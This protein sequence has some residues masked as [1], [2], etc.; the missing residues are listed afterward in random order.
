MQHI[1]PTSFGNKKPLLTRMQ[2]L[3]DAIRIHTVNDHCDSVLYLTM[4]T[5]RDFAA[6]FTNDYLLDN[7]ERANAVLHCKYLY[8]DIYKEGLS[9]SHLIQNEAA[10]LKSY[11]HHFAHIA[12]GLLQAIKDF[13]SRASAVKD[14][15]PI[16]KTLADL[17]DLLLIEPPT[18][19]NSP[20]LTTCTQQGHTPSTPAS[21]P[22]QFFSMSPIT[23]T[24][25]ADIISVDSIDKSDS[26]YSTDVEMD[27]DEE[28]HQ[29]LKS[30]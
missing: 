6:H 12:T 13:H 4:H 25:S 21:S 1:D 8:D 23:R 14:V 22:S 10:N 27:D 11:I 18:P 2:K 24:K 20:A 19:F 16:E 30:Q 29:F 3:A 15:P 9:K 26:G 17:D 7:S 5:I 28:P